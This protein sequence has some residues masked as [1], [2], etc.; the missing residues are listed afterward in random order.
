MA[1]APNSPVYSVLT[2]R[3]PE[4]VRKTISLREVELTLLFLVFFYL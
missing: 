3:T 1:H 4:L 2:E